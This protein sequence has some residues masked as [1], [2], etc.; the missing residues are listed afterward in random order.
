VIGG[1]HLSYYVICRTWFSGC[2]LIA[3]A[4]GGRGK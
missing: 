2:S 4:K 1:L 3:A